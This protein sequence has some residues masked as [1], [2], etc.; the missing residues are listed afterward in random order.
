MEEA[1]SIA[2]RIGIIVDGEIKCLGSI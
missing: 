1:E 2:T